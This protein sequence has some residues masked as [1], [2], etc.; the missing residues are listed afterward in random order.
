MKLTHK[1]DGNIETEWFR[2]E[3]DTGLTLN[4]HSLAPTK[5]KRSLVINLIHR[6][7][8]ATST[9]KKFDKGICEAREILDYNQYPSHWFDNIINQTY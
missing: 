3:T 4:Y 5:Y 7:Y 8:N 9:W 2:K 6:I 1:S